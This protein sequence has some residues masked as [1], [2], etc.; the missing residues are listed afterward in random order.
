MPLRRIGPLYDPKNLWNR[1]FLCQHPEHNPP[2]MILL[3]PGIYE[4]ECPACHRKLVFTVQERAQC[5]R[6]PGPHRVD[7]TMPK[8]PVLW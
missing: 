4:H 5:Y 7:M 8:E 6:K 3:E 1:E 2:T